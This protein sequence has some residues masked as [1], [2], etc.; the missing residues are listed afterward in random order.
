MSGCK[1]PR[2]AWQLWTEGDSDAGKD[3]LEQLE[4]GWHLLR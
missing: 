4:H 3:L 1:I 2:H